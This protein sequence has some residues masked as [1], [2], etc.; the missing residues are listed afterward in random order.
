MNRHGVDPR[1]EAEHPRRPAVVAEQAQQRPD[2]GDF[3]APLGRGAVDLALLD[4]EIE[5]VEGRRLPNILTRPAHR[6]H[7][8]VV[9]CIRVS[10][11]HLLE[12]SESQVTCLIAA[13][14]THFVERIGQ[15]S[16][17]VGMPRVPSLTLAALLIDD[18]GRITAAE[19]ARTLKVSAGS[20]YRRDHVP[21]AARHRC[22]GSARARSPPDVY[23][24]DDDAWHGAMMR[25]DQRHA[26]VVAA[27]S[28]GCAAIGP[29][30]HASQRLML[31]KSPRSST[32]RRR[33]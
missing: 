16:D 20:V 33:P 5:P 28:A 15:P 27:L 4:L 24:V 7:R 19:L 3:P 13:D 21:G 23:M 31:T 2:R 12:S 30:S 8:E 14:A 22:D 11:L 6:D 26:S 18:D 1:I 25:T 17:Q 10:A 9:T 29:G 32:R